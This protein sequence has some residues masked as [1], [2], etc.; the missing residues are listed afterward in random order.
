MFETHRFPS[1]SKAIPDGVAIDPARELMTTRGTRKPDVSSCASLKLA[2]LNRRL[3]DT[4]SE[5]A[6]SKARPA[7]LPR[8]DMVTAGTGDPL[9]ASCAGSNRTRVPFSEL[10]THNRCFLSNARAIGA[11]RELLFLEITMVPAV[12]PERESKVGA[13]PTSVESLSLVTHRVPLASNA[14]PFRSAS[15]ALEEVIA[16]AGVT[17]AV[18]SS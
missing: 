1:A 3:S 6:A 12:D 2:S 18:A 13:R 8:P 7:G 17:A 14:M 9:A 15:A 5:P 4:Q 10:A 11:L 16:V